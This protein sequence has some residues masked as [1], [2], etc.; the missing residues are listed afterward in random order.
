MG[1]PTISKY[2]HLF[3]N[4]PDEFLEDIVWVHRSK[5]GEDAYNRPTWS[6]V[7]E[8]LRGR[9]DFIDAAD[10]AVEQGGRRDTTEAR[11][12]VPIAPLLQDRFEID[13]PPDPSLW[14]I[15]QGTPTVSEGYLE[16]VPVAVPEG[17]DIVK[18]LYAYGISS[19]AVKMT[20]EDFRPIFGYDDPVLGYKAR[21]TQLSNTQV[22]LEVAGTGGSDS[23]TVDVE[24][25]ATNLWQIDRE[26][27]KVSF[28]QD[29]VLLH[30]FTED[31]PEHSLAL[32]VY[33][34]AGTVNPGNPIKVDY[35]NVMNPIRKA[36]HFMVRGRRYAL[37]H[38]PVMTHLQ[39]ELY[40]QEVIPGG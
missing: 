29:G 7:N 36:D 28:Y 15:V 2:A 31:I 35:V 16:L 23:K 40:V 9:V 13:G 22:F 18:S 37:T 17:G 3:H 27:S 33:L 30:S 5:D 34:K 6:E 20:S 8:V 24:D 4:V 26:A 14:S 1:E 12:F 32:D 38:T 25:I 39:Q 21:I 19:L 11:I 10:M